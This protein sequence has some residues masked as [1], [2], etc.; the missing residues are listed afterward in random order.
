[1][2]ATAWNLPRYEQLR[3]ARR[4]LSQIE[5]DTFRGMSVATCR[6]IPRRG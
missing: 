4:D 6:A 2:S 1:M 3:K 5:G